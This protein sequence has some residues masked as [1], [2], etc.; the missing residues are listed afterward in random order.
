[1]NN[2]NCHD[3]LFGTVWQKM[4]KNGCPFKIGQ[5]RPKDAQKTRII[6]TCSE[7]LQDMIW[8]KIEKCF[9]VLPFGFIILHN[10]H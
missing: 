10:L 3:A 5:N 2:S 8:F 9:D 7:S 6:S 4:A 1:V